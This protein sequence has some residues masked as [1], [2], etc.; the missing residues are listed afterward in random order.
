MEK[1]KSRARFGIRYCCYCAS[2]SMKGYTEKFGHISK[3]GS[4]YQNGNFY[5]HVPKNSLI[6]AIQW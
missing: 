6:L 5:Q 3:T 2:Y 4:N 1:V